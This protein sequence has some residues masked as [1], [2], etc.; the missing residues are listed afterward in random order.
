MQ[1]VI[2]AGRSHSKHRAHSSKSVRPNSRHF[3][4]KYTCARNYDWQV[5]TKNQRGINLQTYFFTQRNGVFYYCD[6]ESRVKLTRRAKQ[7][8]AD[9]NMR[10]IVRTRENTEEEQAAMTARQNALYDPYIT[11][12]FL[13]DEEAGEKS[14]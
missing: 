9:R 10:L 12:T 6:V 2:V 5:Q 4:Y 14:D 8:A 13:P 1:F 3:S 7:T 11:G